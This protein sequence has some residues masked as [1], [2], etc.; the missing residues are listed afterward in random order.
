MKK[1]LLLKTTLALALATPLLASAESQLVVGAGSATARLDVRV[2]IPRVLFL[3]VGTGEAGTTTDSTI[4]TLTF[5]LTPTPGSVGSGTPTAGQ[6]VN[7]RVRGNNGQ[8]ALT[9]ATTGALTN[10]TADTIPWSEIAV[11]SDLPALPSP[12]IPLTGTGAGSNVTLNTGKVTDRA[13]VWTY[14]Y[15]NTAV[16]APG[17]YATNGRVTYT[18]SMP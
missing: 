11:S 3:A 7:V 10:A 9:A 13:A 1:A 6:N 15:R 12:V 16:V 17:T 5:D 18:A 14:A 8:V 4:D 2:I